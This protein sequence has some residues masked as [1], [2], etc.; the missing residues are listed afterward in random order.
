MAGFPL[1]ALVAALTQYAKNTHLFD[2]VAPFETA[3]PT[4]QRVTF[5]VWLGRVAPARGGPDW[6][7]PACGWR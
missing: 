1:A 6:T 2:R 4:G 3:D 7:P 5:D